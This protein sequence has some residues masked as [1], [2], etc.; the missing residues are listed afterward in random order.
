MW[1]A[2]FSA[3][4]TRSMS[5]QIGDGISKLYNDGTRFFRLYRDR[6]FLHL[7]LYLMLLALFIRLRQLSRRPNAVTP[8]IAERFVLDRS[9]ASA[10]L[11]AL[12]SVPVLYSDASPQMVRMDPVSCG[13]AVVDTVC[14]QYFP[15]SFGEL[16]TSSRRFMRVDFWRYYLPTQGSWLECCCCGSPCW[17]L[18]H[19]QAAERGAF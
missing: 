1:K 10:L 12:F 16:S 9:F 4:T 11:V 3:G 13:S 7:A 15:H 6:L 17:N 14:L 8:S 5:A 19:L 18:R 2:L